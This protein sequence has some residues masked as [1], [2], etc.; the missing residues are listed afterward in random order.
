MMDV[1]TLFLIL[2]S[3]YGLKPLELGKKTNPCIRVN[4]RELNRV[5]STK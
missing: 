4:T 2:A 1:T 5:P 3:C